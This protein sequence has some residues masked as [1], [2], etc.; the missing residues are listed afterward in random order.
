MPYNTEDLKRLYENTSSCH[1]FD[2]D[3]M[4]FFKSRL[5][6]NF[7]R[8]NDNTALFISTE[9]FNNVRFATVRIAKLINL[10]RDDGR[11]IQKIDISTFGEFNKMNLYRAKK[12]MESA[13][14]K[15]VK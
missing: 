14:L 2:K 9:K 1:W 4:R 5:T 12:L 11:E 6:E 13:T 10:V 3:T 7:R 8:L 15:D